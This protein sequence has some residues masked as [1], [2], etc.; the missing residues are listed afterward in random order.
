MT[1]DNNKMVPS[2]RQPLSGQRVQRISG[3]ITSRHDKSE[4][5]ELKVSTMNVGS[6]VGRS[7]EVVEILARRKI[8]IIM[9]CTRSTVQTRRMQKV[10]LHF[11]HHNCNR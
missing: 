9:L 11:M 8:D 3:L 7:R 4:G 6:M 5:G 10:W 1:T 2:P